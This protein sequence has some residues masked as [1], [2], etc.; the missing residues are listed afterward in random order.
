VIRPARRNARGS[1]TVEIVVATPVLLLLL[2]SVVQFGL[3]YHAQHVAQAAAQEG[4]RAARV[5]D[6]SADAG[7]ER[8]TAFLD[9]AARS[10][11]PNPSVTVERD[12]ERARV[13][14]HGTLRPLIPGL[15]LAVSADAESKVERFRAAVP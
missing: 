5:S 7:H 1:A 4:V 10:L 15:R 14:V 12:G 8:A 2:M 9:D 3:W 6:G 13:E 11:L